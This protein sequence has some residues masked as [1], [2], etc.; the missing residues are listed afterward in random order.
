MYLLSMPLVT[1][2]S[3]WLT[4]KLVCK[5]NVSFCD[6]EILENDDSKLDIEYSV[7]V[8]ARQN[9]PMLVALKYYP[10]LASCIKWYGNMVRTLENKR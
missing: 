6:D 8:Q 3:R 2:V 10:K 9:G 5:A 7:R 1:Y 4:C